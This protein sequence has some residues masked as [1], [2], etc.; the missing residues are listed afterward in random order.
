MNALQCLV[1]PE[2]LLAT[3]FQNFINFIEMM[4]EKMNSKKFQEGAKVLYHEVFVSNQ[5][6]KGTIFD[7]IKNFRQEIM[8]L[9]KLKW[10][11][12]GK[13]CRES[14]QSLHIQISKLSR[15]ASCKELHK[16]CPWLSGYKWCGENDFIEI[17]GQYSGDFKPFVDQHFKIVRFYNDLKVFS[18]KQMPIELKMLGSDGKTHSFIIK[19]GEDLRQDHRIVQVLDLMSRQL[20]MDKNC[21]KNHLKIQTYQV[22]PINSNYG[23]LSVVKDATTITDYLEEASKFIHF[24]KNGQDITFLNFLPSVK[25]SFR[26]FL[27]GDMKSSNWSKIYEQAALR[28]SRQ[29]LVDEMTATEAMF[30]KDMLRRSLMKTAISLETYYILR[31]NFI[32]SLI[33]MN[34]AHWLLG[35]GDRHLNNILIDIK[36]GRLIGID[37]GFAFGAGANL[38]VPET[39]PF[40]LTSQFV[41]V[42]EPMGIDGMIKKNMIHVMRCLRDYS[43]TILIF[44][45]IFVTEPTMDWLM[46]SKQNVVGNID[47]EVSLA[48]SDWNPQARIAIIERK[49]AGANPVKI[50]QDE[51]AISQI[52]VK[53][54]LLNRYKVLTKG[55]VGSIRYGMNNDELTV[56]DQVSCLIDMATD[57]SL[58]ALIYLGWDPWV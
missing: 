10:E 48:S 32:T 39:V 25:E 3:H 50:I 4:G 29:Q 44:L 16:L 30:P 47:T 35:I 42:L 37:F 57:K 36:S 58:L 9:T 22:I 40:R 26:Y 17:P 28:L 41:N 14:A 2:K 38:L 56:Q 24:T 13:K 46:R 43:Q 31:K 8:D 55:E 19:Y 1:I 51:L 5:D 21:K 49:L 33:T 6:M 27:L 23:M 7:R 20:S 15:P 54:E 45:E 11:G 18:S 53:T 12:N 34:I 52:A